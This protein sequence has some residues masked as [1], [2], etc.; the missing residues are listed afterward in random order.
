MERVTIDTPS[1]TRLSVAREFKYVIRTLELAS[2]ILE[3]NAVQRERDPR[4]FMSY[5]QFS[6]RPEDRSAHM[7]WTLFR[8]TQSTE[9]LRD[10]LQDAGMGHRFSVQQVK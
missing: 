8:A 4:S 6:L 3:E 5:G 10:A 7:T 1:Y 9:R 2:E